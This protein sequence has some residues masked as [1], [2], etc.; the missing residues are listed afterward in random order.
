MAD[1]SNLRD[2]GFAKTNPGYVDRDPGFSKAMPGPDRDPGFT[3]LPPKF[4]SNGGV[5]NS[6]Y[7]PTAPKATPGAQVPGFN[8]RRGPSAPDRANNPNRVAGVIGKV[9]DYLGNIK[10]SVRDIPTALG[11]ALDS[12]GAMAAGTN[13]MPS[14][15][16]P[17]K[18]LATQIKEVG[19]SILGKQD[20]TPSDKYVGPNKMYQDNLVRP[21]RGR[22]GR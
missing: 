20:S 14:G 7:G 2:P 15:T 18:N 3:K 19:T 11:T 9:G 8:P 5:G 21:K 12:K 22:G 4:N 1:N 6:P 17:I 10:R 13:G 16:A